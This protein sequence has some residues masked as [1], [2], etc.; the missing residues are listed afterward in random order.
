[1]IW[2]TLISLLVSAGAAQALTPAAPCA[3]NM[4]TLQQIPED[5]YLDQA[6]AG[7]GGLQAITPIYP[8]PLSGGFIDFDWQNEARRFV[9]LHHCPTDHY[10]VWSV[11]ETRF[12]AVHDR[13]VAMIEDER[14][15]TLNE[16]ARRLTA[17]GAKARTGQGGIGRC[18]CIT[19]G[20]AE[21]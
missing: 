20:L 18:D 15:Y 13:Y 1:M 4:Q 9:L 10:L 5:V 16:M 3:L 6:S 2:A 21:D 12:E 14:E 8:I 17:S 19:S 11:Q 7:P